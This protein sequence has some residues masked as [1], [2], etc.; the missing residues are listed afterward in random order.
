MGWAGEIGSAVM[1]ASPGFQAHK[2]LRALALVISGARALLPQTRHSSFSS[3]S[4]ASPCALRCLRLSPKHVTARFPP[5]AQLLPAHCAVSDSPRLS[6]SAHVAFITPQ[7]CQPPGR[8][9][10]SFTLS[11][12]CPS[13]PLECSP[14]RVGPDR[15]QAPRGGRASEFHEDGGQAGRPWGLGE[16]TRWAISLGGKPC[17]AP[18]R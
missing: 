9:L 7:H 13:S 18:A 12:V 16:G 15:W 10:T 6:G 4:S 17:C 3:S 5:P 11:P 1:P 8:V 14:V 2:H